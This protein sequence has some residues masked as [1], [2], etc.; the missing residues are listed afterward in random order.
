MEEIWKPIKDF[1]GFYEVS[2]LGRVRSVERTYTKIDKRWS[3][4]YV[5][6]VKSRILKP[7]I[8]DVHPYPK[9][10]L[11]KST[12]PRKIYTVS[13]HR[14]VAEAFIPNPNNLP[15][16]NHIDHD[17]TNNRVDNL[18][19]VTA[20]QNTKAAIDFGVFSKGVRKLTKLSDKQK[21]WVY[22]LSNRGY[23]KED[24]T[25]IFNTSKAYISEVLKEFEENKFQMNHLNLN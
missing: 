7:S 19:W 21:H 18:E 25:E 23:S 15:T 12:Y 6:R 13:G 3:G 8:N 10:G 11:S 22:L 1:E 16:V 5:V 20:E 14:L 2:N 24:L 17:K 9:Y 4:S